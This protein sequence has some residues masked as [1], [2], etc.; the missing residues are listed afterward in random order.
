MRSAL[1]AFGVTLAIGVAGL[2][3]LGLGRGSDLVYSIGAVPASPIGPIQPGQSACQGPV[4]LPEG[5]SF[6]RV[7][8]VLGT[9]FR[10]G[11]EVRVE[12]LDARTRRRVAT[13]ELPGGYPDIAQAPEHIVRVGR[14]R[15]ERPLDI[16]AVNAGTRRLAVYGQPTIAS[17]TSNG[18]IAGRQVPY[19]FGFELR[20]KKRSLIA[21]APTIAERASLFR[22]GWVTSLTYLVLGL[23]LLI[24]APAA[25]ALAVRRAAAGD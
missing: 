7:A 18:S 16:C 20:A 3:A 13:G 15:T 14:V 11:P 17:P 12:I 21:L 19:D 4:Q 8:M 1:L 22:A 9:Y 5:A 2:L 24:G 6:D 23:L 10:P 25:L